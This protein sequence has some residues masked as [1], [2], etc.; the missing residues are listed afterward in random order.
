M[1]RLSY[2]KCSY[3]NRLNESRSVFD[4]NMYKGKYDNTSKC[5]VAFGVVGGY[6]DSLYAGNQTDLES[7]LFGQTRKLSDCPSKKFQPG[8]YYP[9]INQRTCDLVKYKTPYT[10]QTYGF[11]WLMQKLG[12]M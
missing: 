5:R 1:N 6:G 7:D 9:L 2:D 12:F 4:Y 11:T 3:D 10:G 8:G